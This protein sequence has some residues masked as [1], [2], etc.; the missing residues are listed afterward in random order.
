MGRW[1]DAVLEETLSLLLGL[2]NQK[3][4]RV[5]TLGLL[6]CDVNLIAHIFRSNH[7]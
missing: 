4:V 5:S 6:D 1:F 7:A 2:Q 3:F